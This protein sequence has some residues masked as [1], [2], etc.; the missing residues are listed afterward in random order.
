MDEIE[1]VLLARVGRQADVAGIDAG[2]GRRLVL[3]GDVDVRRGVVAD[4]HRRK[5]DV[6][7][8]G[9]LARDVLAD[10]RRKSLV[11]SMRTAVIERDSTGPTGREEGLNRSAVRADNP[12]EDIPQPHP[13][14]DR[15]MFF[16]IAFAGIAIIA[17]MVVAQDQRWAQRAGVTGALHL[18]PGPRVRSP[19]APGMPASRAC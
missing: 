18:H 4:E 8:R 10:A 19:T 2:L 13:N 11:P 16:K 9:N 6:A 12:S 7:E 5:A 17:L 14:R 3:R 15:T 1:N